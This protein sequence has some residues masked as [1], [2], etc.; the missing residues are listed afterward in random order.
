MS[1][2]PALQDQPAPDDVLTWLIAGDPA[3]WQAQ[4]DLMA[5][6]VAT[7]SKTRR[8]VTREGWGAELIGHRAPDGTWGGGWYSPKWTSTFY[9]LQLLAI[10]GGGGHPDAAATGRLLLDRGVGDDGAV[11]LWV[12][13]HPDTCVT[14]SCCRSPA[15]SGSEPTPRAGRWPTRSC[16]SRW[17][18]AVGTAS[19]GAGHA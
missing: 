2:H 19:E 9:S 18:T 11:R 12:T 1:R 13:Q 17:T 14:G 7:S 15:P 10:L 8:R 5:L 3:V 6:P 4:C 16:A